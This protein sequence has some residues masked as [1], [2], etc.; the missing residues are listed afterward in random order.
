[1]IW[2]FSFGVG[3]VRV[4][5]ICDLVF[6]VL[7]VG[8]VVG[9]GCFLC[10]YLMLC[11]LVCFLFVWFG[12]FA[13]GLCVLIACYFVLLRW[14]T[15]DLDTAVTL[16]TWCFVMFIGFAGIY[17]LW[18]WLG[19]CEMCC[20]ILGLFVCCGFDVLVIGLVL[21]GFGFC[22]M[23]YF[24]LVFELGLLLLDLLVVVFRFI[25]VLLVG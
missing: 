5:F 13:F 15:V 1:M 8:W 12:V 2:C 6:W 7:I 16:L 11:T 23:E 14:V 20:L 3:L 19:L 25:L 17:G 9:F 22:R 10:F 21:L 4:C 24:D 18:V